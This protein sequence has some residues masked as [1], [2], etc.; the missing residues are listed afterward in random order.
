MVEVKVN[1]TPNANNGGSAVTG[2]KVEYETYYGSG[3]VM[4]LYSCK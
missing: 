2:F 4:E 1:W 3:I